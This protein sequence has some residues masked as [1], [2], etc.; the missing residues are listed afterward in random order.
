MFIARQIKLYS[1]RRAGTQ[2]MAKVVEV[3]SWQEPRIK[4]YY[5]Q[6]RLAPRWQYEVIAEWTDPTNEQTYVFTSERKNG[7]PMSKK[8]DYLPA[9]ISPKGNYLELQ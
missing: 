8:G 2:V 1:I 9:Y 6:S 5:M 4:D 7:L 3:H